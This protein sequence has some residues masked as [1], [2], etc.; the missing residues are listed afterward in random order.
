MRNKSL[1]N[2]KII[3]TGASSGI[4]KEMAI[5]AASRGAVP[6]LLARSLDKLQMI[7]RHIHHD[8]DIVPDIHSLDVSDSDA[9]RLV[10][11]EMIEKHKD[12]DALIN[13][14]GFGV[15]DYF[16]EASPDDIKRM[17]EVN[18]IGLMVCTRMLVPYMLKRNRGH[19]INVASIAGKLATPKSTVYAASKHAVLGFTNGLRM[20]LAKTNIHVTAVNPGP[21]RT[22]F[23]DIADPSGQYIANVSRYIVEPEQV[24]K[25]VVNVI[26]TNTREVNI[27][28]TMNAGARLYQF[29]PR[30]VEK[31][32][33]NLLNKK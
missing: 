2:R 32:A 1:K 18:V 29:F 13:N 26:G 25:R 3:I 31:A 4:G 10:F 19:I 9:V 17:F 5:I 27:P 23:F 11:N 7:Q 8:Y 12:I 14:A 24:A 6:I 20:E 28:W 22:N 16:S 21:I 15:F 33:A 30:L